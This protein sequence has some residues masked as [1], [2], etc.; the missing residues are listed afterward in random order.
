MTV[1]QISHLLQQTLK[2]AATKPKVRPYKRRSSSLP[3]CQRRYILEKRVQSDMHPGLS[4]TLDQDLI[5]DTGTAAHTTIQRYLSLAGM[6]FGNWR[7]RRENWDTGQM[8]WHLETDKVG[9]VYCPKCKSLMVYEEYKVQDPVSLFTG[10]PDGLLIFPKLERYASV[11]RILLEIKTISDHLLTNLTMPKFDHM[12]QASFYGMTM[13]LC[14]PELIPEVDYIVYLYVSRGYPSTRKI[15]VMPPLDKSLTILRDSITQVE[16]EYLLQ[17]ILP[18][19]IC[20]NAADGH[21]RYCPWAGL[22]F[23]P[24]IESMLLPVSAIQDQPVS[25]SILD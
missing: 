21:K 7:C 24:M 2:K 11:V 8:C 1:E 10:R 15:L 14:Y 16:N 4:Q 12:M 3:F 23:S 5:M 6:L 20:N 19:G 13:P 17:G 22:C 18:L 9:P 25:A